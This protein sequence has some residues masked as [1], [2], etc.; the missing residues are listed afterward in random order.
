MLITKID[1]FNKLQ[2]YLNHNITLFHLVDWAEI[3]M[4]D[5]DFAESDFEIIRDI[6]SRLGV[7]DVRAFG[8]TWEDC[9]SIVNTLGYKV[10]LDFEYV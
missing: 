5:S 7:A 8:L 2:Q 4:M 6:V 3:A 9:E 1:V 10:K